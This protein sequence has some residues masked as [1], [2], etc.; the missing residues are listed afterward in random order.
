MDRQD[1]LGKERAYSYRL[2]REAEVS[3]HVVDNTIYQQSGFSLAPQW[4]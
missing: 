4:Q 1:G 3:G 2:Y